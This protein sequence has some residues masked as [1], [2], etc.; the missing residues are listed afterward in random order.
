MTDTK[1]T[2]RHKFKINST[3]CDDSETTELCDEAVRVNAGS[4][5]GFVYA[6]WAENRTTRLI[7]SWLPGWSCS[8]AQIVDRDDQSVQTRSWDIVVHQ[9]PPPDWPPACNPPNGYPLVP[10]DLCCVAINVKTNFAP[11][12]IGAALKEKAYGQD[13]GGDAIETER[14]QISLLLPEVPVVY[15][16]LT[17]YG[18]HDRTDEVA[19]NAGLRAFV[20]AR[21]RDGQGR[22]DEAGKRIYDWELQTTPRGEPPLQ[23]FRKHLEGCARE[24]NKRHRT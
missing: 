9:P 19:R 22:R 24:W 5:R 8:H 23:L 12:Q 21:L 4:L 18:T 7:Q 13:A 11:S 17:A 3:R 20:L 14:G 10:K 6:S 1:Y 15:F 16:C 2:P